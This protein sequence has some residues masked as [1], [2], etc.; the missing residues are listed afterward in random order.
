M[1]SYIDLAKQLLN[2]TE[3]IPAKAWIMACDK[4]TL[5]FSVAAIDIEVRR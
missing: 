3:S 2:E 5:L 4:R 1:I